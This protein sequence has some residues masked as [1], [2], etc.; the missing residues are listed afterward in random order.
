[1]SYKND[2]VSDVLTVLASIRDDFNRY[3][4]RNSTELRK[5]AVKDIAESELRATKRFKDLGSA[6][7]CLHDACA[8]RLRP[9]IY[10]I[11]DFDEIVDQWL[12]NKSMKLR[13]ILLKHSESTSQVGMINEFF[14]AN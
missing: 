3:R 14:A 4:N 11:N 5:D 13:E 2:K 7:K 1:M 8:R 10:C 9:D 6:E 12:R